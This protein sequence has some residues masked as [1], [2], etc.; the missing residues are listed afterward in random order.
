MFILVVMAVFLESISKSS[1]SKL[2]KVKLVVCRKERGLRI[3]FMMKESSA[4][5]SVVNP[6]VTN[7]LMILKEEVVSTSQSM[8]VTKPACE[9]HTLTLLL[10]TAIRELSEGRVTLM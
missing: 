2:V 1:L 7:P 10:R 6:P 4:V 9:V 3:P 5:P 8:A